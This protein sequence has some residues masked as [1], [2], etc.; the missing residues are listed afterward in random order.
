MI[1]RYDM[2]F[3]SNEEYHE[4]IPIESSDGEW[5]KHEDLLKMIPNKKE[6]YY[7]PTDSSESRLDRCRDRGYN[8]CIDEI[9]KNI[10]V[11]NVLGI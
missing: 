10:G 9:N 5:V 6:L 7:S 8:N 11:E 4:L 2:D 3:V 1:K